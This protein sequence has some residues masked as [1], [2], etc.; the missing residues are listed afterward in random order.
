MLFIN[1]D[2]FEFYQD[3]IIEG[4]VSLALTQP[5][6][7][8]ELKVYLGS[9]S[10]TKVV[11]NGFS[12][13]SSN[14]KTGNKRKIHSEV[15]VDLSKFKGYATD[16]KYGN[17][18][19]IEVTSIPEGI[20]ELN[21]KFDLNKGSYSNINFKGTL[22]S[23]E[24]TGTVKN[25]IVASLKSNKKFEKEFQLDI[26]QAI[27]IRPCPNNPNLALTT[28]SCVHNSN[29]KKISLN[30]YSDKYYCIPTEGLTLKI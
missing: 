9:K 14:T 27:T 13:S 6:I 25:Y 23:R 26:Q 21:F 20:H 30:I 19:I 15:K 24:C 8:D 17:G 7:V 5:L 4:K 10:E 1:L 22:K 29:G 11:P 28:Y 2:K 3:D 18:N 12:S 16:D